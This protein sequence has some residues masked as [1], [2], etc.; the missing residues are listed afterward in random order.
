MHSI[1]LE[2]IL[3]HFA[4]EAEEYSFKEINNGLIN[5][6]FHV[7]NEAGKPKYFLQQIDDKVFK[8]IEGLMNNIEVVINH[9]KKNQTEVQHLELIKLRAED[10]TL[11]NSK[12]TFWRLYKFVEGQTYFR[13]ENNALATEAGQAFGDF[14]GAIADI[15]P[16]D[17]VETIPRFHDMELRY[18]QFLASVETASPER[19]AAT[20]QLRSL[21]EQQI[22]EMLKYY[23]AIKTSCRKQ[24]THNDTKLSNLIFDDSG[25][26]KMVIDYDTLM[27]GYIPLDYG[28]SVRTICSTTVEDSK[29]LEH[30]AYDLDLLRSFTNAFIDSLGK[31]LNRKELAFLPK[32]ICYMPFIMGLRMLT[33]YLNGDIYYSIKYPAHNFD[34]AANQFTLYMSG[35]DIQDELDNIVKIH[36][37]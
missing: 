4:I 19:L 1:E 2:N 22:V 35:L 8:N 28:D 23:S 27:P 3:C 30:T 26:A 6:S 34:R 20:E 11:L 10:K 12:N 21:V 37:A 14:L 9:L 36:L 16:S 5:N 32:A 15:N 29:E 7:A 33:D 31:A 24:V 17:L 13:A 18:Q 25:K